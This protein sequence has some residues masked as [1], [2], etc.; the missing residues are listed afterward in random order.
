M[1]LKG[2]IRNSNC[3]SWVSS[4]IRR[5]LLNWVVQ[6]WGIF[7]RLRWD[8]WKVPDWSRWSWS[9]PRGSPHWW[10]RSWH[11][12]FSAKGMTPWPWFWG[13]IYSRCS[14]SAFALTWDS[15]RRPRFLIKDRSLQPPKGWTLFLSRFLS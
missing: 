4:A 14:T 7:F 11:R 2:D 15:F 12:L 10:S 9:S 13:C 1:A 5:P 8:P 6:Y 3:S